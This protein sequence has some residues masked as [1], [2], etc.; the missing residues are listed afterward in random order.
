MS[1][2]S[3]DE[4]D[5]KLEKLRKL[6]VFDAKAMEELSCMASMRQYKCNGYFNN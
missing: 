4:D 6:T 2:A 1:K 5:D 3:L